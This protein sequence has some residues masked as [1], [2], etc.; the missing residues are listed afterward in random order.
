MP[1]TF[2]QRFQPQE[3]HKLAIKVEQDSLLLNKALATQD[4]VSAT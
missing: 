3:P 1:E 4:E 2:F